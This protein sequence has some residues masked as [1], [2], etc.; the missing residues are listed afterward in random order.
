MNESPSPL[1]MLF[2]RHTRLPCSG[3]RKKG[4]INRLSRLVGKPARAPVIYL[5]SSA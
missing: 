3:G 4:G 1:T 2:S 5:Q